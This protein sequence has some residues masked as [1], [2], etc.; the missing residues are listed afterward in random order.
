[1][2]CERGREEPSAMVLLI[3]SMLRISIAHCASC[4]RS[5]CSP[6]AA[7]A[8]AVLPPRFSPFPPLSV[9]VCNRD[10]SGWLP[11]VRRTRIA[12]HSTMCTISHCSD[13]SEVN[14][15]THTTT[16]SHTA[17]EKRSARLHRYAR[18]WDLF[19]NVR[20]HCAIFVYVCTHRC[21]RDLL[22]CVLFFVFFSPSLHACCRLQG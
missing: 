21:C 9:C 20:S 7:A 15:H 11:F 22:L 6:S 8:A 19:H 2:G 16:N 17:A 10:C 1:M 12:L 14:T 18:C 4:V 5:S 3:A 13:F